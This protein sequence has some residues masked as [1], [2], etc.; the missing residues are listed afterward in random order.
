VKD[1][2]VTSLAT[3]RLTKLVID[4]EILREPREILLSRLYASDSA[5]A[6]K[7][8]YLLTCP[9]CVSIWAG[10]GLLLLKHVA[11]GAYQLIARALA[12]S[13]VTGLLHEKI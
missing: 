2:V 9:W 4:D 3:Y 7:A 6:Q 11:P 10:G 8:A 13:A 1:L 5:L 12:A